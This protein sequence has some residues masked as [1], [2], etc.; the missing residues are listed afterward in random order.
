[1]VPLLRRI[2]ELLQNAVLSPSRVTDY[3]DGQSKRE[4]EVLGLISKGFT[5]KEIG[6]Y[7]HI[8]IKTVATHARHI[9]LN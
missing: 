7:L 9:Y 8:S 2:T 5:N 3:P 6:G 4:I 1:M